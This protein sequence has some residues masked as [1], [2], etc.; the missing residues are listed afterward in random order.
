[1]N[2][3]DTALIVVVYF[4]YTNG[5]HEGFVKFCVIEVFKFWVILRSIKEGC[6]GLSL[7]MP[8]SGIP[9]FFQQLSVFYSRLYFYSSHDMCFAWSV[10]SDM[11]LF[12]FYFL[13]KSS[14]LAGHTFL[15]EPK[16]YHDL[17]ELL[18]MLH[19]NLYLLWNCSSASL[20]SF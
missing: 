14:I 7:G 20:I 6:K 8:P 5:S 15:R 12:L 17:L 9:A 4:S 1:M 3:F 10:L 2:W 16:L 11:C 19:L 18:S 13:F